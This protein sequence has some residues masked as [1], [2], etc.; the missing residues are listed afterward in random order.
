MG[1]QKGINL[2]SAAVDL[3]AVSEKDKADLKF[4]VD[5]NLDIVFASFIR[6]VSAVHKIREILGKFDKS[7]SDITVYPH[8][9]SI[10]FKFR[11]RLSIFLAVNL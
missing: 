7:V 10:R 2:P 1:S 3:P 5:H 11:L 8:F 4:A 9:L 6:D